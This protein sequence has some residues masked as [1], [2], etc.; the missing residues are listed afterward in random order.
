MVHMRIS[1][2][3]VM[4]PASHR[5]GWVNRQARPVKPA[6]TL[7][8][9]SNLSSLT[10]LGY[11]WW[12]ARSLT[13]LSGSS[14]H[15]SREAAL[16]L[17]LCEPRAGERWL[18]AGTSGGF[19]AGVLAGAGCEVLAAD[20]SSAMLDVARG[21][22][23][24]PKVVWAYLN[25]EDSGMPDADFDGIT[26]GATLNETHDPERFLGECARLLRPGGQLW[27]MYLTRTGGPLQQLLG[28][29][30]LGG[31][32]FPDPAQVTRWLAPLTPVTAF[33]VGNVR[34]ERHLRP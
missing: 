22:V 8:Q 3:A 9:R 2:M 16:F 21:R 19:Y 7:A 4:S 24:D 30:G 11:P 5:Q 6:L 14:F 23:H 18:D 17:K 20:L 33:S 10:A 13:L 32:N 34:F 27:L 12:R 26:V 25:I 31:L 28:H 1:I 29:P 15:L